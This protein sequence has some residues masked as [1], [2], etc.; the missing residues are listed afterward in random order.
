MLLLLFYFNILLGVL[1]YSSTSITVLKTIIAK[2]T[3]NVCAPETAFKLIMRLNCYSVFTL[4][5]NFRTN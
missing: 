2:S 4:V 1:P 5:E 3:N